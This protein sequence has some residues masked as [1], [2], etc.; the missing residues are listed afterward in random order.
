[1]IEPAAPLKSALNAAANQPADLYE[2]YLDSGTLYYSDQQIDWGGHTYL[3]YVRSRSAIKRYDGGQFDN[4]TVTFSNV[5][6]A[7]AQALL[8]NEIEGRTLIIRKIDRTVADDSIVLFHGP[9]ERPGRITE[10]DAEISAQQVLGS[11]DFDAPARSFGPFCPWPFKGYECGYAGGAAT[12]DK[13]WSNCAA[14]NNTSRFGGF[15]FVPHS[16][17]FQYAEVESKRAWYSLG[18]L[19][20][21]KTKWI[22]ATFEAVDDT[23][24]GVPIPIVYGRVQMS[25]V[26]VQHADQGGVTKALVAFCIGAIENIYYLRANN[27]YITD[28]T[29]HQGDLGGNGG[30]G[31]DPRF[32]Q[33]YEYNLLA[34]AGVTIPS[35]VRAVDPAPA[36]TAVITGRKVAVFGPGGV[37]QGSFW[38]DNPIWCVRDFMT[39][40]LQQGGLG[41]PDSMFDDAMNAQ[42]AAYADELITDSTNDQKIYDPPDLPE[43]I[44]YERYRSTGVN[45]SDPETPYPGDE[46]VPGADDDSSRNPVPVQVKRFTMNVAIAKQEKAV[47][48]LFKKLLPSFRGYLTFSKD[49]KIQIRCER[50]VKASQVTGAAVPGQ[51]EILCSNPAQWTVGEK[52]IASPLTGNAEALTIA[53]V[54]GDRLQFNS[55][56][57]K[58][59]DAGDE[60]L[61]IAMAFDDSNLVGSIEYPLSDRVSSANRITV[62]YVDAPAGFEQRELQVNDFEHQAKVHR[63]N[64]QDLDGS[65]ID[66]Y[67][68][69]WRIGEWAR[70]KARDLGKFCCLRADIKAT[71][72]EVGD[73]IAVSGQEVG[74]QA[75]PF[76][77]IE[78]GFEE[79]DEVSIAGQ[80]YASGIYDD[81]AP[82]ATVAVPTVFGPANVPPGDVQPIG[83]VAFTLTKVEDGINATLTGQYNPPAAIGTFI[84]VR[85]H[86]ESPDG[87]L[88]IS[89]AVSYDY[90]GDPAGA[91][92]ARYGNFKLVIPQP[93]DA[94]RNVR[95]YLTPRAAGRDVPLVLHGT[96][97]ESPNVV[98]A[99]SQAT[100]PLAAPDPIGPTACSVSV[101]ESGDTFGLRTNWTPANPYGGTVAYE[102]EVRYYSDA[103]A[104]TPIS[105][106][107]PL[108]DRYGG[109]ENT[110]DSG[111]WPK[112]TVATY[113][114]FRVR[115]VNADGDV[116]AWLESSTPLPQVPLSAGYSVPAPPDPTA[117]AVAVSDDGSNFG[118]TTSW[119]PAGDLGSTAGYEREVRYYSD[120]NAATPESDWIPLG[121]V[122]LVTT[123]DSGPWPR[124]DTAQY[125]R[126]RVRAFN[127][128]EGK[129]NWVYSATP[130]PVVSALATPPAPATN[131]T[132]VETE[133]VDGVDVFRFALAC[134]SGGGSTDG[135]QAQARYYSDAEAT[136]PESDWIPLGW[137]DPADPTLNTDWWERR[138]LQ[139]AKVRIAAQNARNVLGPWLESAV[140]TVPAKGTPGDYSFAVP[141]TVDV[142]PATGGLVVRF[143]PG[144]PNP[145]TYVGGF[146]V[147]LEF[148]DQSVSAPVVMDGSVTMDGSHAMGGVPQPQT[149][150]PYVY[151]AA[152]GEVSLPEQ[153]DPGVAT[154]GRVRIV[155]VS[156]TGVQKPWA[157]APTATF[158]YTPAGDVP[159]PAAA[160]AYCEPAQWNGTAVASAPYEL[161][162]VLSQ[163]IA[164]TGITPA[165]DPRTSGWEIW[166]SEWPDDP[167][168]YLELD[169]KRHV[170]GTFTIECPRTRFSIRLWLR[171]YH[172][173]RN[174]RIWRNPLVLLCTPST[175]LEIGT[176]GGTLNLG[177]TIPA[178]VG[179]ALAIAN[180]QLG[181]AL[182][183]GMTLDGS[184]RAIVDLGAGLAADVTGKV[185]V[186]LGSGLVN[187]L[188]GALQ[189]ALG[190][191]L[192]FTPGQ[193]VTLNLG[194]GMTM[195]GGAITAN[196]GDGLVASGGAITLNLGNG[197]TMSG[198]AL[199]ANLGNGLTTSGGAITLNLGD[200][201]VMNG[202]AI[203]ANLG[204]G[205][206]TSSGAIT[207]NLGNGLEMS[208]AA[209]QAKLGDGMEFS[210]TAMQVKTGDGL[211]LSGGA[212]QANL[213]NG[214]TS[215]LGAITLNLGSGLTMNGAVVQ[216]NLGNGLTTSGGLTISGG[217]VTTNL[218][219]GLTLSGAAITLSLG[220]GLTL[221]GSVA[222]V[223]AA[224][225]LSFAGLQLVI[226]QNGVT[227]DQILSL[228]VSKL[229]TGTMTI[230][231]GGITFTGT[232]N[233]LVYG[234]G[235]VSATPG[236]LYGELLRVGALQGWRMTGGMSPSCGP[237]GTSWA[238]YDGAEYK[239]YGFQVIDSARCLRNV[240]D[241]DMTGW[242]YQDGVAVL[243]GQQAHVA[244]PTGG[245]V[246]DDECRAALA[247]LL[248]RLEAAGILASF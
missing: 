96:A 194:D 205:L 210:G 11:I 68:Q 57:T 228:N 19:K 201:L 246:V 45:G 176:T 185:K 34:Y 163:D 180:E 32:P 209:V 131:T 82:Q 152:Q 55:A 179:S 69:A 141:P 213:G 38:S 196:L 224:G 236:G 175:L 62:K 21:K 66:S 85:A 225:G 99:I 178:S 78:L 123:A 200:G 70:A 100:P 46:Y 234:G 241:I 48:I 22:S 60:L 39:L 108:G 101:L 109:A 206:T 40:P 114:R 129:G 215:S 128:V 226:A 43:D 148:P 24:Y 137:L 233:L 130:L 94:G 7:L 154:Q 161:N 17:T 26:V 1:M 190:D 169:L 79:N 64:N 202:A 177:A 135:F 166:S 27:S 18:L 164:I 8:E 235:H 142:N 170:T 204:N 165:D 15:R 119:T 171:S 136:T 153:P 134:T 216:A 189:L 54:L 211:V 184:N 63:V 44:A 150:G 198:S 122:G 41:L 2:L 197:L 117:A 58:A 14:L 243:K 133:V 76:R 219:A 111:Y 222:Q 229:N 112:P 104:A 12:C 195:T 155:T 231:D 52:L 244:D 83:G 36:V 247:T 139:Y 89:Q 160:N 245:D 118:L 102:R 115:A 77:V 72:L 124:P 81:T 151:G 35:D 25:G 217:A 220:N 188:T 214:L 240:V 80:V 53:Q 159:K 221:N 127:A 126:F 218:G 42:E 191:G 47:D 95:V 125:V 146:M 107:I 181:V 172:V 120:A 59:H 174:G 6:T 173:D 187:D 92:A 239:V 97:G 167:E 84:G 157:T 182:G 67:F 212:V 10:T 207:L 223:N 71:L 49:G 192:Q 105:A 87:S 33:G 23:P 50:P 9:M 13:S 91:G 30:Q 5:D 61:K 149:F 74:L 103:N 29:L 28:Y 138:G 31:V 156:Q 121:P 186:A 145:A 248:S 162:G 238:T 144:N 168:A 86:V 140:L 132:T 227:S 193:Q 199:I 16:G 3:P 20:R 208:G 143:T 203:Q 65:A 232:G 98:V 237:Y 230:G 93:A 106:W 183:A 4:V 116:T 73:V 75:V 37:F 51:T 147:Q 110:A 88:V 90:D 158:T 242:L 113:T 56:L